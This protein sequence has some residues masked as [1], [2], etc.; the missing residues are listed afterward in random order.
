METKITDGKINLKGNLVF[1]EPAEEGG[2][3]LYI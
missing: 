1:R 2:L 3:C